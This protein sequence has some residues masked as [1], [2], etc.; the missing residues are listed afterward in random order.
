MPLRITLKPH[1]RVFLG[2]AAVVN[3]DGKCVLVVL[4]DVAVLREKDILTDASANT[5]CK[6]IYLAVQLMYMDQA[7]LAHC[8]TL[9]WSLVQDVAGAAPSTGDLIDQISGHVVSGQY[10]PALK[11]ARQ[12]V[13]YEKE[14]TRDVRQSH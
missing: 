12:L 2:G 5:P 9:Y 13:Q 8:H 14:L 6:R 4:N 11:V 7:N 1:E 10:Y 3:G